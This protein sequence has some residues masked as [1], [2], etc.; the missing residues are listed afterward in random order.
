MK[1]RFFSSEIRITEESKVAEK[2]KPLFQRLDLE[3]EMKY[4]EAR[5]NNEEE[6]Q[7]KPEIT[8]EDFNK[9]DLRIG[10]ILGAEKVKDAEKLL[11]LKVK[12]GDETRT[13]VSGIAK[14]YR[15]EDLVGKKVAVLANLK[16]VKIRGHLSQGMLLCAEGEGKPLEVLEVSK[17]DSRSRIL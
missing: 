2:V 9:L 1:N 5:N 3:A 11:L 17:N 7:T 16:P 14:Y 13:I 8:I 12:I 15:P 4:H 6:T 10:E